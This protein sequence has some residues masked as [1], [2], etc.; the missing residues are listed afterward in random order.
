MLRRLKDDQRTAVKKRGV[1]LVNREHTYTPVDACLRQIQ[2]VPAA[3]D[4]HGRLPGGQRGCGC[5]HTVGLDCS[6]SHVIYID[7]VCKV[8]DYLRCL[9]II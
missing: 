7:Q 4:V 1:I 5:G 9:R 6:R 3:V 2:M 8:L